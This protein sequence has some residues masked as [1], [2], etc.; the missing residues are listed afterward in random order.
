M[1]E[2]DKGGGVEEVKSSLSASEKTK[3][4]HTR[5]CFMGG[6]GRDWEKRAEGLKNQCYK[7]HGE[8]KEGGFRVA[9]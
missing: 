2:L 7:N 9:S 4:K 6:K 1:E 8:R 5:D 3:K